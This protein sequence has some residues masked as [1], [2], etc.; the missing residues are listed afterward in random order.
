MKA[1]LDFE[2]KISD[3]FDINDTTI[4]EWVNKVGNDLTDPTNGL[5]AR[6]Q[7]AIDSVDSTAWD[8][9]LGEF[10]Q[11]IT[12]WVNELKDKINELGL[13]LQDAMDIDNALTI[14]SDIEGANADAI[15]KINEANET[16]WTN[17]QMQAIWDKE[18]QNYQTSRQAVIDAVATYGAGSS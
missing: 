5:G 1:L 14:V 8:T 15:N 11:K 12:D 3:T 18:Y 6:L 7:G 16:G 2:Q 13:A 10:T 4:T 17:P 9:K